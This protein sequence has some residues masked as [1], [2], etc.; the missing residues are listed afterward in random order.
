[1]SGCTPTTEVRYVYNELDEFKFNVDPAK[2]P[3]PTPM[4]QVPIQPKA[5]EVP[6]SVVLQIATV[7]NLACL[8]TEADY[9]F[10]RKEYIALTVAITE[11]VDRYNKLAKQSSAEA[12]SKK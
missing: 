8:K 9:E 12:E 10:L 1:M 4:K 2:L 3:V 6:S 7:N 11:Y 5:T